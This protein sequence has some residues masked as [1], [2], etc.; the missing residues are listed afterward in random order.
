MEKKI[1]D[2]EDPIVAVIIRM[3]INQEA[4]QRPNSANESDDLH[5]LISL[6]NGE[7]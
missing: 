3:F 6:V 2:S 1:K 5:L 4:N 7:K